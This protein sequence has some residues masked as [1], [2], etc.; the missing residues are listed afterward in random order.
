MKWV[1]GYVEMEIPLPEGFQP[2]EGQFPTYKV[3]LELK[4]SADGLDYWQKN[5]GVPCSGPQQLL[6]KWVTT[7]YP[8]ITIQRPGRFYQ[9]V[10]RLQLP[11]TGPKA[12]IGDELTQYLARTWVQHVTRKYSQAQGMHTE[13]LI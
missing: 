5:P 2:T 1:P 13:T 10:E 3:L 12:L 9:T 11:T 4:N 7:I 8:A 6:A